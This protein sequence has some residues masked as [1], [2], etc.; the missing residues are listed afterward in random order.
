MPVSTM[1]VRESQAGVKAVLE[2]GIGTMISGVHSSMVGFAQEGY[3]PGGS[4]RAWRDFF[5]NA[6]IYGMDVQPDTQFNDEKRIVTFL[7]NSIDPDQVG[8]MMGKLGNAKFDIIIDDGSHVIDDQFKTLRN[9]FP[10]LK[11]GGITSSRMLG[12]TSLRSKPV[13]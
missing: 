13:G 11:G 10:F 8:E 2:I 4:L 12:I 9:F 1:F 6:T 3:K 5:P 7:C